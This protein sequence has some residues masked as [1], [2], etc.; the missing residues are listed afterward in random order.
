MGVAQ[1]DPVP[2][3]R[4]LQTVLRLIGAVAA[5]EGARGVLQ[6]T[7]QVV[8]GG[9]APANVDSEFRFYASWYCVLGV[10]LLGAARRP[11]AATVAVRATGTGFLMAACGRVLSMRS[12]G[13]PHP[14]QRLLM[15][16]ELAIPAVIV[17]WQTS[18]ARRVGKEVRGPSLRAD[19]R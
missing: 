15:A 18:V 6:G 9:S 16:A 17:P 3:R 14:S 7:G 10:L 8:G 11:E 2:G 13:L 12:R 19:P 4:A 1:G 5:V